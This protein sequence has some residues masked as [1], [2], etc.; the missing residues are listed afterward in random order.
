MQL[1]GTDRLRLGPAREKLAQLAGGRRGVWVALGGLCAAGGVA[2]SLVGA[3]ALASKDASSA[4]REF[5]ANGA[6]LAAALRLGIEHEEDLAT[7]ASAFMAS[8]PQ[9][10]QAEFDAWR[11]SAR[12][13]QRHP[14]LRA[15]GFVELAPAQ[16]AATT[17]ARVAP[18]AGAAPAASAAAGAGAAAGAR[19]AAARNS[20]LQPTAV[21]GRPVTVAG[22]PYRCLSVGWSA[23]GGTRALLSCG[24]VRVLAAHGTS[25]S[26][27]R[28]LS[29]AGAP[30]LGVDVP[31]YGNVASSP[32]SGVAPGKPAFVGWV[33][34]VLAPQAILAATLAGHPDYAG[35]LRLKSGGA[36]L[37]FTAAGQPAGGAAGTAGGA[38]QT[39]ETLAGLPH[40]WSARLYGPRASADMLSN[41]DALALLVVGVV[42]SALLGAVVAVGGATARRPGPAPAQPQQTPRDDLYDQLTGLPNRLLTME[43]AKRMLARTGRQ[44]GMLAGA[45]VID[46]D[47]FKDINDKLGRA[48]GNQA[49]RIVAERLESVVRAGDMVG[50][51]EEDRFVVLVECQ[52]QGVRLESLA[53]RAIEALREPLGLEGFGPSFCLTAS[54][55]IALGRYTD[56]E[57]LLR[58]AQL[59]LQSSK[60]AGKD[61]F[62]LFNANMRALIEDRG[63]LEAEMSEGLAE[64][65]FFLLYE[66]IF[67]LGTR[68]VVGFEALIRWR[69]PARGVILAGDFLPLAEETGLT[70]PIGRWALEEACTRA[71]A[72]SVMGHRVSVSV[73]VSPHQ[74]HRDGF[75]ID[76]RRA[77]QQSGIEPS[78]LVL[79]VAE[80]TVMGDIEGVAVR[81]REIKQLGVRVAVNDFGNGYAYRSDLQ[82]LPL[83]YLKVDRGSIAASDD[84]DYR[85]WLLEAILLFARDLSV[86][87]IAKGVTTEEQL[88]SLTRMGCTLAQGAL[89][90]APVST[91]GAARLFEAPG[92]ATPQLTQAGSAS[93]ADAGPGG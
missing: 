78:L 86:S 25:R 67:D 55:G 64:K 52:A 84:E 20:G 3:H 19:T 62:T 39:S 66:P 77:L 33:R 4:R 69:H 81:L 76:V 37:L 75:A 21:G 85:S 51:L 93:Q 6:G 2:G 7:G 63:V 41:G 43:L 14:D 57:E 8:H 87:V 65:Q 36:S 61:R 40:G 32:L 56:A 15:L 10:S 11:H 46:V 70:V 27:Y 24:L 89:L 53:G 48:A 42:A 72:W 50:R 17:A 38:E 9:A 82:K 92:P 5:G 22:H 58:D 60:D 1:F 73:E 13:S 12:V 18:G 44:A 35:R 71:A 59:A 88:A 26:S 34:E 54:I 74:L 47:W 45:L 28:S 23:D 30:A 16:A 68:E 31:V 80:A 83:D 90:G 79:Q 49:L 29:W 91:E